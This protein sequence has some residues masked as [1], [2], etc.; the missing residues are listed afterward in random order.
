ML[1]NERRR[2]VDLAT[3]HGLPSIAGATEF[4]GLVGSSRIERALLTV[5]RRSATCVDKILKGATPADLPVEQPTT[6]DLVINLRTAKA[7]GLTIA[8]SV[9][10]RADRMIQ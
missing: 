1:F 7:L 2:I 10:V 4:A 8:Q 3:Q 9:L 5:P 6:F